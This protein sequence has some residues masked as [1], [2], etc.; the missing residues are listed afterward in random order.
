MVSSVILA[1]ADKR[2][3]HFLS[4]II[5]A[6]FA[7]LF[8]IT[9]S[10]HIHPHPHYS[11]YFH[12]LLHSTH[13]PPC[14]S[15]LCSSSISLCCIMLHCCVVLS[16]P[17]VQELRPSAQVPLCDGGTAGAAG[18]DVARR[19]SVRFRQAQTAAKKP[20]CWMVLWWLHKLSLIMLL[21]VVVVIVV[22]IVSFPSL[23]L[24]SSGLY[25]T[26]RGQCLEVSAK[27]MPYCQ[28]G[29]CAFLSGGSA[30]C[31]ACKHTLRE[32]NN[33]NYTMAVDS[34]PELSLSLSHL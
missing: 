17:M 32:C 34:H 4:A 7:G 3:I 15:P 13:C 29:Y 33:G 12:L 16:V 14:S 8:L 20:H 30:C 11:H 23:L 31:A 10:D 6:S 2:Y 25:D 22:S 28:S 26:V 24:C 19:H 9:V 21:V 5:I 27:S 18:A 1:F